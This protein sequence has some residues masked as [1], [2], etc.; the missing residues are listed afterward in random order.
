MPCPGPTWTGLCADGVGYEA[1]S[2]DPRDQGAAMNSPPLSGF[3]P[4]EEWHSTTHRFVV[5]GHKGYVTV[6]SDEHGRPVHLEIRMSRAGGVL[7]GLLDSLAVSV[8]L[9]LQRG[10][11]LSDY[12][13]Q[14][15]LRFPRPGAV[16]PPGAAP[17]GE[18]WPVCGCPVTWGPG[19]PCA[20]CGDIALPAAARQPAPPPAQ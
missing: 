8:S 19:E 1:R 5:D 7:R 13:E 2:T 9:G 15:V 16:D 12:V 14:L 11:P 20:D 17:D 4:V 6:P 18:T 10:V 3:Q